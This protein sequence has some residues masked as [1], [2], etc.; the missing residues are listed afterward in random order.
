[1]NDQMTM[2]GENSRLF[3]SIPEATEHLVYREK[4][5]LLHPEYS[6]WM[7]SGDVA[8]SIRPPAP[9]M[10]G[11]VGTSGGRQ[12]AGMG[13][14]PPIITE[15]EYKERR[16]Q[17]MSRPWVPIGIPVDYQVQVPLQP[18]YDPYVSLYAAAE[19]L[20]D[21]V[22]TEGRKLARDILNQG[23]PP[24][25][26]MVTVVHTPILAMPNQETGFY[27]WTS[28]EQ[29]AAV[30][31]AIANRE[32]AYSTSGQVPFEPPNNIEMKMLIHAEEHLEKMGVL[33][34]KRNLANRTPLEAVLEAVKRA[35]REGHE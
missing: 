26:I 7:L 33:D 1:M 14:K 13:R 17:P 22:A 11:G 6:A 31:G 25:L 2:D 20:R 8:V 34:P 18:E 5:P 24:F 32:E 29:F 3:P 27:L 16:G 4:P 21:E 19:V 30:P 9:K 23:G 12:A 28:L 15:E 35:R 10:M